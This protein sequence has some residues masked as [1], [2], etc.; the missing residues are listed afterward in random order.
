MKKPFSIKRHADVQDIQHAFYFFYFF[1]IMPNNLTMMPQYR[2]HHTI[3]KRGWS[4]H[5]WIKTSLKH[6]SFSKVTALREDLCSLTALVYYSHRFPQSSITYIIWKCTVVKIKLL[7][8]VWCIEN[9]VLHAPITLS[10]YTCTH[11]YTSYYDYNWYLCINL[12]TTVRL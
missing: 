3:I 11:K 9:R 8:L 1:N 4:Q 2:C 5:V 12:D 6:Q 7:Q 10:V